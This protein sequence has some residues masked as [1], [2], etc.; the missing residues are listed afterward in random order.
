[1]SQAQATPESRRQLHSRIARLRRRLDRRVDRAV[2]RSL[3][4]GPWREFVQQHPARSLLAAV[5]LGMFLSTSMAKTR[6]SNRLPAGLMEL[7]G[8]AAWGRIWQD[9]KSAFL[10]EE[11]QAVHD[12]MS[13]EE[14]SDA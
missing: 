5:G 12:A 4:F 1:M 9:L 14:E 13:D 3:L 7:A 11:E 6:L 10:H 2:D 8:E